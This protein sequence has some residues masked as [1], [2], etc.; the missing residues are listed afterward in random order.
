[1][2]PH[3]HRMGRPQVEDGEDIFQIL[4]TAVNITK[5]RGLVAGRRDSSPGSED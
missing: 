1:M 2:E 4:S 3:R 5:S